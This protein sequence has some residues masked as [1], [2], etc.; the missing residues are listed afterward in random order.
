M[1]TRKGHLWWGMARKSD[2]IFQWLWPQGWQR[3]SESSSSP[4][5]GSFHWALEGTSSLVS[6]Q[7]FFSPSSLHGWGGTLLCCPSFLSYRAGAMFR[8]E[9]LRQSSLVGVR[10]T[11]I[12]KLHKVRRENGADLVK[13]PEWEH[14]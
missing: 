3:G 13:Q 8:Q 2:I 11:K 12:N 9:I 7:G 4:E 14:R 1:E 10:K 5:A 6:S